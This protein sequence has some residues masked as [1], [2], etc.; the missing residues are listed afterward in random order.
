L[1][2]GGRRTDRYS[3]AALTLLIN[4]KSNLKRKEVKKDMEGKNVPV[5]AGYWRFYRN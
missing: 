2:I 3:R 5:W 4:H 1:V